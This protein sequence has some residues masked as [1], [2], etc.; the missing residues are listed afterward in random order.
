MLDSCSPSG[1]SPSASLAA[2][3]TASSGS[4]PMSAAQEIVRAQAATNKTWRF[5]A[6]DSN[7]DNTNMSA[8]GQHWL[9]GRTPIRGHIRRAV[10]LSQMSYEYQV[11]EPARAL[12]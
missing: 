12:F 2:G 7:V 4:S 3:S 6:R 10:Q 9:P 1:A 8:G 11:G 5:I